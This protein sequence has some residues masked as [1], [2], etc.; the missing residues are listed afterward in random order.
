MDTESFL[1]S[2]F[3]Q[4]GFQGYSQAE[5]RAV[6]IL[7]HAEG[8]RLRWL[9]PLTRS[10]R[11]YAMTQTPFTHACFALSVALI[12]VTVRNEG[13]VELRLANLW[14]LAAVATLTAR[15][16]LLAAVVRAAPVEVA[17]SPFLRLAPL[18]AALLGA[19]YWV[20]TATIFIGHTLDLVTLVVLLTFVL[21]SV[22]CIAMTPASP[23]ACVSYLFP[24]WLTVTYELLRSDWV[25]LPTLVIL[26][27]LLAAISWSTFYTVVAGTRRYLV[28]S[29]AVDLLISELRGRNS[30]IEGLRADAAHEFANRSAFFESASH[31]FR[32]RVH[33]MK[34]LVLMNTERSAEVGGKVT[35][36]RLSAVVEDLETYMTD[37]LEFARLDR[38][39]RGPERKHLELQHIFQRVD[40]AFEDI[41]AAK[42]VD[43]R[44][45]ATPL[46]LYTDGAML[47]RILENLVSNAIKFSRDRVLLSARQRGLEVH[48]EVRD[49]GPGIADEDLGGVFDAFYQGHYDPAESRRGF[50]LGLAIVKR[51]V[52]SLGYRID[53]VSQPSRG[54]LMRLIVPTEDVVKT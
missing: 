45:R 46:V 28:R 20:W 40:V 26:L 50:G 9:F 12:Y 48:I 54:T 51:L 30:D 5:M 49:R 13:A 44:V 8:S 14:L 53:V 29:D 10:T 1:G 18:I 31:D 34:L 33:A 38:A 11:D 36:A 21:L 52:E 37:V 3:E 2:V 42:N 23:A 6:S 39:S 22:A 4:R 15:S 17:R 24:I 32:Q 7:T 43:L 41:A 19:A 47:L 35:L 25:S 16:L 27:A